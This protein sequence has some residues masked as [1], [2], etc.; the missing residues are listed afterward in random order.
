MEIITEYQTIQRS[1]NHELDKAVNKALRNGF[2]PYGTPLIIG[3]V[4]N[5]L[6]P[7]SYISQAMVKYRS[8]NEQVKP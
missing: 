8:V 2:Q 1:T 7:K 3:T 4:A 5:P 6:K